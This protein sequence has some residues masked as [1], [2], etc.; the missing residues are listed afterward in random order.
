MQHVP[1]SLRVT[2]FK[3]GKAGVWTARFR[4]GGRS[5]RKSLGTANLQHAKTLANEVD[6]SLLNAGT[7]PLAT[8][9]VTEAVTAYLRE[10]RDVELK[11]H[12]TM[13][14]YTRKLKIL[15]EACG[16]MNV[17]HVT[18]L[19][20]RVVQAIRTKYAALHDPTTIYN[21]CI[22]IKQFA[23]WLDNWGHIS[24]SPFRTL[25]FHK[26]KVKPKLFLTVEQVWKLLSKTSG[27]R[28]AQLAV[29]AFTGMRVGELRYLRPQDVQLSSH[30]GFIEIVARNDW[31]PKTVA[32]R[33]I[34]I[35]PVLHAFLANM[36]KRKRPYYFWSELNPVTRRVADQLNP[37]SLLLH[38]QS[39]ANDLEL[40][41]MRKNQG[42]VVHSLRDF[43]ETTCVHA[44][45]LQFV[46]DL[47][48]GHASGKAMGRT[49]FGMH[50]E[51]SHQHMRHV[52]FDRPGQI[53]HSPKGESV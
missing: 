41:V 28:Q 51:E 37:K 19:S 8:L 22:V 33:R 50:D 34:P 15:A 27:Q 2:I 43:F 9:T 32:A 12:R 24:R 26:P 4:Q 29:L 46:V 14:G 18:E 45:I 47:W 49:Y 6:R 40:P 48:I 35:H 52:G 44:R 30:G 53:S 31:S 38:L 1:I 13:L 7:M 3:R 10:K 20:P 17:R 23:N 25:R 21:T 36:P 5:R 16:E 11:K 39:L 42:L